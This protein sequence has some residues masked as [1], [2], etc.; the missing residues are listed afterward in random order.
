MLARE[1]PEPVCHCAEPTGDRPVKKRIAWYLALGTNAC[2]AVRGG[3]AAA[4]PT[5]WRRNRRAAERRGHMLGEGVVGV[6][7]AVREISSL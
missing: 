7:I 5:G 6:S 3:R 2:E 4:T 1:A